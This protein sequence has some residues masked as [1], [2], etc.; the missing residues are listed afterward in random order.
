MSAPRPHVLVVDDDTRLRALLVRFLRE[1]GCLV[2]DAADAGE[3]RRY[4]ALFAVDLMILDV[5]MPGESGI[6]LAQSL[7]AE[8]RPPVL[9]LSARA[10]AQDRVRGLEAGVDD[11]LTKPFEPR[12]LELRVQAILRRT[13][14]APQASVRFGDYEFH[15]ERQ[16][17]LHRGEPVH[18]TTSETLLLAS[19]AQQPGEIVAREALA[20][21]AGNERS[22][23]V[24]ITR[25]RRKIE[26]GEG[27]PQHIQTVRGVGYVLHAARP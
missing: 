5:M 2:G 3:A 6:D 16:Q 27:R 26:P 1:R 22:V 7:P 20:E 24:Q 10:D 14:A 15:L 21:R 12:E 19:L 11:Y 13:A 9:M 23:D 18:L 17:L 8:S 25:L 4:L